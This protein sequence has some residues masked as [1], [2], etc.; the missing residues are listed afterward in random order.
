MRS[1]VT[2][3]FVFCG[4]AACAKP[5]TTTTSEGTPEPS[6]AASTSEA[7]AASHDGPQAARERR[8]LTQR[9]LPLVVVVPG[10]AKVEAPAVKIADNA[11]DL[12]IKCDGDPD[13]EK[14]AFAIQVG[15][16]QG[17]VGK[18]EIAAQ[19]NFKRFTRD[20][21]DLLEW[22]TETFGV[23]GK[24]FMLRTKVAGVEYVCFPATLR[25]DAELFPAQL[26]ACRSLAPGGG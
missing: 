22:E 1:S 8:D 9:G 4:L 13:G 11:R 10:C 18:K 16:A 3:L 26:E 7:P 15:P 24:E 5:A 14:Q 6:P 23:A 12:L 2:A 20:D 19:P 17:K 21:P 25:Y